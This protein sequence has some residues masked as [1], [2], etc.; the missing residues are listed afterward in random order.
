MGID[1]EFSIFQL[2]SI[3]NQ[4]NMS[5]YIPILYPHMNVSKYFMDLQFPKLVLTNVVCVYGF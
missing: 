4:V 3:P 5:N 2:K 1:L